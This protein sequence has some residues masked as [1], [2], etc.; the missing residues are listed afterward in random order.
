[1]LLDLN[2][3]KL[4]GLEVLREVR[5]HEETKTLPVVIMSTSV[6]QEEITEGYSSGAN[7]F[8]NKPVDYDQF[9]LA[10]EQFGRYWLQLNQSPGSHN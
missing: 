4:H 7:S 5:S 3:P 9:L 2:L 1:M 10:I 8:I 6:E